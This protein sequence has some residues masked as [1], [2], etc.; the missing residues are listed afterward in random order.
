MSGSEFVGNAGYYQD[1]NDG[2]YVRA[3]YL[4]KRKTR[5][6]TGD[7]YYIDSYNIYLYVNNN[8]VNF[9]DKTGWYHTEKC[10]LEKR[11]I[12]HNFMMN[13]I[14]NRQGLVDK[15]FEACICKNCNRVSGPTDQCLPNICGNDDFI[16]SCEE[17]NYS[18]YLCSNPKFGHKVA[19]AEQ[20]QQAQV[21]NLLICIKFISVQIF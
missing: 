3:R 14:C 10:S 6:N 19:C 9:I 5:W 7:I 15:D 2:V 1:R 8:P 13:Y 17:N 11:T 21:L 18:K 20:I 16:I 12:I 4:D